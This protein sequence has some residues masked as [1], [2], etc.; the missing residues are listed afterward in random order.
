MN[1]ARL[2]CLIELHRY[3]VGF[4]AGSLP[5]ALANCAADLTPKSTLVGKCYANMYDRSFKEANDGDM[6][7]SI[8]YTVVNI[9]RSD[10][11]R[12]KP[13]SKDFIKFAGEKFEIVSAPYKAD[14]RGEY[15]RFEVARKV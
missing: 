4:P 9:R 2:R 12:L 7:T 6:L 8:A 13:T 14:A 11:E 1:S 3:A 10:Y 15:Y 5:V